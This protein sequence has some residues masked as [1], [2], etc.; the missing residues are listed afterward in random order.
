MRDDTP[1]LQSARFAV[2]VVDTVY[3]VTLD[4]DG[5]PEHPPLVSVSRCGKLLADHNTLDVVLRHLTSDA[6]RTAAT[7]AHERAVEMLRHT[8]PPETEG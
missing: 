1:T 8:T 6:A 7:W 3:Y 2:R 4:P 5:W